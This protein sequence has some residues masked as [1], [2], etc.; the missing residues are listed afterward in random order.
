M[1]KA[2]FSSSTSDVL[3]AKYV[4]KKTFKTLL[5]ALGCSLLFL[6]KATHRLYVLGDFQGILTQ[7]TTNYTGI[8][9]FIKGLF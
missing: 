1:G 4:E 7:V 6:G 5:L 3:K 8:E 2:R 9:T